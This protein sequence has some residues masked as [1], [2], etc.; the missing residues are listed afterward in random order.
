MTRKA[1]LLLAVFGAA[2]GV[3]GL[4][5]PA[6][7]D[8]TSHRAVRSFSAPWTLPGGA[9]EVTITAAGYGGFGQ[10][11]ETLPSGFRYQGS[12]LSEA[13]VKVEGRTVSFLLLGDERFTYTVATPGAEGSYSFAGVLLDAD[14]AE[15]A[16]G[17]DSSIR[18]GPAPTPTPEPMATLTPE[19][20]PE[21]GAT[22][23]AT[24]EPMATPTPETTPEPGATATATP[25]PTATSSPPDSTPT[26]TP[27]G[28][29][30][31]SPTPPA[32]V[33]LTV[34]EA[35]TA[36]PAP[37]TPTATTMPPAPTPEPTASPTAVPSAEDGGAN[38][39]MIVLIVVLVAATIAGGGAIVVMRRRGR[40]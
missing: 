22:A 39:G 4:L 8:A 23:A 30:T 28:T 2:V 6:P 21:P 7:A 9:L 40:W 18:V 35:P 10:V 29:V 14:R 24:P 3:V 26:P 31:P 33:R 13:A 34:R 27:G 19:T 32:T 11:V 15:Q 20:T 25:E 36:V 5:Y 1:L 38:V 16:I 17:G 37:A 12:D